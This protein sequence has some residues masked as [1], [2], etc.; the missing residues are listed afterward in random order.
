MWC[1]RCELYIAPIDPRLPGPGE[2]NILNFLLIGNDYNAFF[3]QQQNNP[4]VK[5]NPHGMICPKC[6]GTDLQMNGPPGTRRVASDFEDGVRDG[7]S[8]LS[9]HIEDVKSILDNIES[10]SVHRISGVSERHLNLL[11]LNHEYREGFYQCLKQ[12]YLSKTAKPPEKE[13]LDHFKFKMQL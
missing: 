5:R 2:Y 6:G 10:K 1:N 11:G 13:K 4:S 8:Y 12:Y 7:A 9:L 3:L